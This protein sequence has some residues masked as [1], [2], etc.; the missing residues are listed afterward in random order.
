MDRGV[1]MP[2]LGSECLPTPTPLLCALLFAYYWLSGT[3]DRLRAIGLKH[4]GSDHLM[5]DSIWLAADV[6]SVPTGDA[7]RRELACGS[8]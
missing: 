7:T 2:L 8:S 5:A 6:G 4:L 1:R 3:I